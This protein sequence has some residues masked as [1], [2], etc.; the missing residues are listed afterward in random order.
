M[1]QLIAAHR[2]EK[3]GLLSNARTVLLGSTYYQREQLRTIISHVCPFYL[4]CL[5]MSMGG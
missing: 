1:A 4:L 3:L 5:H 2:N